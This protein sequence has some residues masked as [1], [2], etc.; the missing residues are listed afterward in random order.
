M[1]E[2]RE[3]LEIGFETFEIKLHFNF[4]YFVIYLD[5]GLKKITLASLEWTFEIRV[6]H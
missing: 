5:T 6:G 2:Q 1:E 4:F 3:E